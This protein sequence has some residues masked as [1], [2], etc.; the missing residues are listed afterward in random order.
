MCHTCGS[1][2]VGAQNQRARRQ[3]LEAQR[4]DIVIPLKGSGSMGFDNTL[5]ACAL[6][7]KPQVRALECIV[8]T[9]EST[10]FSNALDMRC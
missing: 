6:D 9:C 8:D 7:L 5:G 3:S 4:T 2:A 1:Y 10:F